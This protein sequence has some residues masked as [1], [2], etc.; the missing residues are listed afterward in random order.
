MVMVMTGLHFIQN[1]VNAEKMLC[2]ILKGIGFK[3]KGKAIYT[4]IGVIV[5]KTVGI[6]L[7]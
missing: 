6:K 5:Y 1:A 4:P 7:E 2:R 3:M